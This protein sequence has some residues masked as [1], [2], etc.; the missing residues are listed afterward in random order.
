VFVFRTGTLRSIIFALGGSLLVFGFFETAIFAVV[1]DGLG[2]SA[3][4]VGPLS[5]IKGTGSVAGGLLSARL[6]DQL[7][8]SRLT[9]VGL[10]LVAAGTAV[11][12][13]PQ[14]AVVMVSCLVIG[15]GIPMAVVGLY[16]AVQRHSPPDLQ[17]RVFAAADSLVTTPQVISVG[18]G[19]A[20]IGTVG[21]RP[22]LAAA[23]I[24][25]GASGVA[26]YLHRRSRE[27]PAT[28]GAAAVSEPR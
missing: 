26:L 15:L 27:E 17:G 28:A 25:V 14:V 23:A 22:M 20:L 18:L 16:T 24:A 5:A 12:Q 11:M 7:G 21:F 2:R 13:V 4:F 9:A 8:E 6:V 3:A 19:A 10:L 1:D